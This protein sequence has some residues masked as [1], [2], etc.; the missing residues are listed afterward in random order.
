M[1]MF[2][3]LFII[4][5]VLIL[6]K[7]CIF[8]LSTPQGLLKCRNFYN[9]FHD[10][11]LKLNLKYFGISS[12]FEITNITLFSKVRMKIIEFLFKLSNYL[13]VISKNSFLI[14]LARI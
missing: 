2:F 6:I 10:S 1:F 5:H 12:S 7:Y 3:Y 9:K 4:E 13:L 8:F 14:L 11:L